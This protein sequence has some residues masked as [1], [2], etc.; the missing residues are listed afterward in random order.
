M[1][2]QRP[3]LM[4]GWRGSFRVARAGEERGTPFYLAVDLPAALGVPAW[5]AASA[6]RLDIDE[7]EAASQRSAFS[8]ASNGR[9]YTHQCS[10]AMG[11]GSSTTL[12]VAEEAYWI[13]RRAIDFVW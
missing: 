3:G 6:S 4:A 9:E 2:L 11:D 10:S 1:P 7:E 12:T 8:A 5:L 13:C